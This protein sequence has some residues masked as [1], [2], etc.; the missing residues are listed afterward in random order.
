MTR[1]PT[2]RLCALYAIVAFLLLAPSFGRA[3]SSLPP[4]SLYAVRRSPAG[5]PFSGGG[6]GLRGGGGTEVEAE[7]RARRGRDGLVGMRRV[8]RPVEMP[9]EPEHPGATLSGPD[10]GRALPIDDASIH[11]G[12]RGLVCYRARLATR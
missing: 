12:G 11:D 6:P 3:A 7:G 4:F 10:E 9:G 5:P 2:P 1:N 8:C